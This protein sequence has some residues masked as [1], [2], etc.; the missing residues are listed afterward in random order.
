ML[1]LVK[2]RVIF[3]YTLNLSPI[4][5]PVIKR[6]KDKLDRQRSS[7]EKFVNLEGKQRASVNLST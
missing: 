2:R 5:I 7:E 3:F 6:E 1:K 4:L